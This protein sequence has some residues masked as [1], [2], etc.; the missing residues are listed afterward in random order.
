MWNLG[1]FVGGI[2]RGVK[3]P[4]KPPKP[5]NAQ[6]TPGQAAA[7]MVRTHVQER[8]VETPTGKVT[9]R[10]TVIDEIEPDTKG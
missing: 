2:T 7:V 3:A 5:E 1:A 4:L 8:V 9:L 6:E 10:R